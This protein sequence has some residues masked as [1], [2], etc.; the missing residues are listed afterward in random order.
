MAEQKKYVSLSKLGLYDEKI[1]AH[2]A[3]ADTTVLNQA[4]AYADGLADNYEAAGAVATAKSELETKITAIEAKADAA[5]ADADTAQGDVDALETLVGSLPETATASTVVGYIDEKTSGIATDG[6][7]TALAARVATAEADIDAIEADYLKAADKTELSDAITAEVSRADAAEKVNAAA[8]DAIKSDYLKAADKAAL[9]TSIAA[10]KKAGDDAQADI[11]AFMAA[12][13]VGDA[14]VDT[15]KEIQDYI[16]SDGQAAATM[17][18]NISANASAIEDLD[19]KVGDIPEEATAANVV[20]YVNEVVGAEQTR[21]TGIEGGLNTRLAAVESAVGTSGS[22]ATDIATAKQEAIDSAVATAAADA[23]NKANQ[24]LVDAK[25][26]ADEEDAKI[27]TRVAALETASATHALSS[28]LTAL[29]T[30]VTTAEGEIDTLQSE[31]DAVEALAAANKSAHEANTAAIA[32]KASQD[33]LDAAIV[34]I[35]ANEEAIA[36]F[37]ECSE[38]EINQLFA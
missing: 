8:I 7:V 4:K 33:D 10:A 37:V 26:Y 28:D 23:A 13:E 1:K 20:A 31:M 21:A 2:L 19:D 14:A 22:V 27:E 36:S 34:R 9:E 3:S 25:A 38:T 18:A 6:A 29:A 15:L 5:Q 32:L 12:A 35:A 17:T 16:T 30:R 11:D 24:A